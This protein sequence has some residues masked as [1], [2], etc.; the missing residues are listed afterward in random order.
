MD[1]ITLPFIYA[2]NEIFFSDVQL[3]Y[4]KRILKA[5]CHHVNTPGF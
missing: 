4:L 2:L 1:G 5:L 3:Q